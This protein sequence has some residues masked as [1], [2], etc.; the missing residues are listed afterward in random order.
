MERRRPQNRTRKDRQ[1]ATVRADYIDPESMGWTDACSATGRAAKELK[2]PR[3]RT[4]REGGRK[5]RRKGE[6]EK[7]GTAEEPGDGLMGPVT[8]QV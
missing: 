5:G 6:E 3:R 4:R 7:E 8:G 1:A 2:P